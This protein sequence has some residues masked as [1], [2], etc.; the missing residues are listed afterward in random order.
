MLLTVG[1]VVRPH[2]IRGEVVVE[3]HTDEP[4]E[5][6]APGAELLVEAP[7]RPAGAP[8]RLRVAASRSHQ[9]R[10]IVAFDGVDDRTAAEALRGILLRVDS[11]ELPELEDPEEYFDHQLIGLT[12]VGTDGE[13]IGVVERIDHAPAAD[14]LVVGR[15][16]GRTTLVP[17]VAAL[18]P[19]VD[20]PGGRIV[21]DP[22]P[23]LLDL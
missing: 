5:R 21:V 10:L 9:H 22:P 8:A 11:E 15:P 2:G 12:V 19:E 18:V 13:R 23:G 4:A 16:D 14:L 7:H 3:V 20:L 6:F 1:R 17:F